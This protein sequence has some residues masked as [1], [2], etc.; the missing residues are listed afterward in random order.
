MGIGM[1]TCDN[2][3]LTWNNRCCDEYIVLYPEIN[4]RSFGFIAVNYGDLKFPYRNVVEAISNEKKKEI[5]RDDKLL[6]STFKSFPF[7]ILTQKKFTFK[8]RFE[9]VT[10]LSF[11]P[12]QIRYKRWLTSC[13]VLNLIQ[14]IHCAR[15]EIQK[16]KLRL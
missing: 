1:Y 2:F 12:E 5:L 14:P 6:Y 10:V 9:I 8:K 15:I 4:S 13:R 7:Y 11:S 16:R 3:H